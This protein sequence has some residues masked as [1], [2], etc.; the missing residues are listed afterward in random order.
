MMS[1]KRESMRK[2]GWM[3]G[4][5]G[6]FLGLSEAETKYVE[7]KRSLARSLKERRSGK[8]L[9]QVEL[10]NLV[11]SSQSRVATMEAGGPGVS[12]DLLV[13]CLFALGATKKDLVKMIS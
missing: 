13:R 9:T 12:I 10:A 5:A 3:S 8:K 1:G 4:D 11:Q 6:D 7:L 2:K